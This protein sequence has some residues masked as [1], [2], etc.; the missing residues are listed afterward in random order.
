MEGK[1]ADQEP[2]CCHSERPLRHRGKEVSEGA[3]EHRGGLAPRGF[4][5]KTRLLCLG[6]GP[7][8]IFERSKQAQPHSSTRMSLT[9]AF[10]HADSFTRR[11]F[12]GQD[13]AGRVLAKDVVPRPVDEHQQ[14]VAVSYEIEEVD[15][16]PEEPGRETGEGPPV[17]HGRRLVPADGGHRSPVAVVE[18]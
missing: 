6:E 3:G 9:A 4:G 15:A 11:R 14:A 13:P 7:E 2:H 1:P 18:R 12:R 17:G 8:S 16:Q 10:D 5:A